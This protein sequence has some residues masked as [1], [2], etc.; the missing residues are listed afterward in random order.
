[1]RYSDIFKE[2]I[3]CSNEKEVFEYLIRT[4]KDTI[5]KWDYFINWA[6]VF[7][8]LRDVEIDLN[9][10]N[11]LVGKDDIEEAFALLLKKHPSIVR[12]IPILIACRQN[13]FKILIN[14]GYEK[15]EYKNYVFKKQKILTDSQIQDT[16]EFAKSVGFLELLKNKKIKNVVDYVIGIE[17]GLDS[18]GRKNRGGTTMEDILEF[19]IRDICIRNNWE[20]VAQATATKIYEKWGKKLT[21]DKSSRRI[22][23]AINNGTSLYL[24]ET[25]FYGGGGSKLKSTAGEYIT[26]FN[27]WRNDGHK[28]IWVTDGC[29]WVT[30][31]KPLEETFNK[32][33]YIL[34]LDMVSRKLLERIMVENK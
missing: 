33:D 18:N 31:R 4:L 24:V 21:V 16:I 6:K 13:D 25:N 9:I 7:D 3:D 27:Y 1:M 14:Y 15:F 22:D 12:L 20:Y 17:A 11:Y 29:G 32:I 19:F 10:L 34:N 8:N 2:T 23:F 28:F 26:M 5:T 30:T